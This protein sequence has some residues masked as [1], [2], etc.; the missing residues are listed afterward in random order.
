M[1]LGEPGLPSIANK[2]GAMSLG[3]PR[4]VDKDVATTIPVDQRLITS[5]VLFTDEAQVVT[6][7]LVKRNGA[8]VV[9]SHDGQGAPPGSAV[10]QS[11]RGSSLIC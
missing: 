3:A 11:L 9:W 6:D 10:L 4:M 5:D 7:D 1:A 8:P 2:V